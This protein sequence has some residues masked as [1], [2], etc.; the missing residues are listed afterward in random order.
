MTDEAFARLFVVSLFVVSGN[1]V[2]LHPAEDRLQDLLVFW[3]ADAAVRHWDHCVGVA[4]IEAG[5]RTV[6]A[7]LYRNLFLVSVMPGLSHTHNGMHDCINLFRCK[8][9]DPDQ[10]FAHLFL[11]EGKLLFVVQGQRGC[12]RK[13]EGSRMRSRWP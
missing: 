2:R 11:F 13:G 7:L 3:A 12:T 1:I 5:H 4:G 6:F 8:A 9:S 10:V